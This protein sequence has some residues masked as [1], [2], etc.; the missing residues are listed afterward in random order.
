MTGI[1]KFQKK[2]TNISTGIKYSSVSVFRSSMLPDI[3]KEE[4]KKENTPD[5]SHWNY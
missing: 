4:S 2:T 1:S 3:E 5:D